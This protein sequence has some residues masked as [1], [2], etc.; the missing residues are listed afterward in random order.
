[1]AMLMPALKINNPEKAVAVATAFVQLTIVKE[2]EENGWGYGY[3]KSWLPGNFGIPCRKK[4]KQAGIFQALR[5]LRIIRQRVASNR[6]R[7]TGWTVGRRAK[8]R[9]DGDYTEN[10]RKANVQ[11]SEIVEKL[12]IVDPRNWTTTLSRIPGR[13]GPVFGRKAWQRSGDGSR[14]R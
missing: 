4:A 11:K 12:L 9:L 10:W 13:I 3:L 6:H 14:R 1:M 2:R 5:D 8:A 7:A